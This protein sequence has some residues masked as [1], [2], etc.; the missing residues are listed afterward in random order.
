MDELETAVKEY[1]KAKIGEGNIVT[2]K[3][4]RN[5]VVPDF[6]S[7][8]NLLSDILSGIR[9]F[10]RRLVNEK[11]LH[12]VRPGAYLYWP[13][14]RPEVKLTNQNQLIE[15]TRASDLAPIPQAETYALSPVASLSIPLP[16]DSV[17]S[18]SLSDEFLIQRGLAEVDLQALQGLSF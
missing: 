1:L 12:H 9:R 4:L 15:R 16:F 14:G 17:A 6:V 7:R 18:L 2:V 3:E 11:I 10:I 13:K 5:D 8:G